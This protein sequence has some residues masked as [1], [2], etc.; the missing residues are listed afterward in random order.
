M[1]VVLPTL[2][3]QDRFIKLI[4][5]AQLEKEIMGA[6]VQKRRA[7]MDGIIKSFSN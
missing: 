3:E 1:E 6:L 2:Q 5:A 7:F 4:Q